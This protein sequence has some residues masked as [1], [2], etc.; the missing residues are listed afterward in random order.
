MNSIKSVKLAAVVERVGD[1]AK[2][3][4]DEW[5]KVHKKCA[6][7]NTFL[8]INS[9]FSDLPNKFGSL[10]ELAKLAEEAKTKKETKIR[11]KQCEKLLA[12][13]SDLVDTL[14]KDIANCTKTGE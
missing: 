2:A 1:R 9:A 5:S 14:E 4:Q 7:D 13:M 12:H 6:D 8:R 3:L 10:A 11:L